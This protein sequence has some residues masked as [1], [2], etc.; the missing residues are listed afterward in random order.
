MRNPHPPVILHVEKLCFAY[1]GQPALAADWTASIGPGVTLLHGDT[2]SGKSTLLRVLAGAQAA[3]GR[4]MLNGA[5]LDTD[6]EAYRRGVFF[7]DPAT[8]VFDPLTVRACTARLREG[9]DSFDELAWQRLI[10]GFALAPHLEKSMYML[11]T[12]SK[13]KVWLAAALASSR[14]LLLL[15][16]PTGGLDAASIRCLW[17]ALSACAQVRAVVVASG[18]Q[19]D[20][21]PLA[22]T[23][24]LPIR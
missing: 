10:D 6:P 3:R 8:D 5:R 12:G 13:R 2:G 18:E 23:I 24:E 15:D 11:S 20:T 17:S 9:D 22:A 16:E 4:L 7:V 1:P 14:P 19:V 21:L